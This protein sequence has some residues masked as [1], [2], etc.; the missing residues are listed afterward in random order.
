M[1]NVAL[2]RVVDIAVRIQTAILM[3]KSDSEAEAVWNREY[4]GL[5][6]AIRAAAETDF[7]PTD[8][9]FGRVPSGW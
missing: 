8:E 1:D 6:A 7:L 9:S 4:G 3:T 5:V 2:G